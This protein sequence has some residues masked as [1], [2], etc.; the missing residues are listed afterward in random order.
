MATTAG[1][2]VWLF[3]VYP[4]AQQS[5][6]LGHDTALSWLLKALVTALGRARDLQLMPPSV[7]ATTAAAFDEL[8]PTAEQSVLDGHDRPLRSTSP[9]G[10]ARD[11]QALPPVVVETTVAPLEVDPTAKQTFV[12]GHETP[13]RR[14]PRTL[15]GASDLHLAPPLIV[16]TMTPSSAAFCPTAQQSFVLGH[17]TAVS[18]L[19]EPGRASDVQVLPPSVVATTAAPFEVAPTAQQSFLVGHE[20]AVSPL[21]NVLVMRL[22]RV[23]VVHVP[24][25][26]VVATTAAE[27]ERVRVPTAQQSSLFGHD[28]PSRST[29]PLGRSSDVQVP[30]PSVVAAT[31]AL[32]RPYPTAQQSA[33]VGQDTLCT[34]RRNGGYA[35]CRLHEPANCG[36]V[37]AARAADELTTDTSTRTATHRTEAPV[38]MTIRVDD[39][40]NRGVPGPKA[41]FLTVR[42]PGPPERACH[43]RAVVIDC[44]PT[45][46]GK[47]AHLLAKKPGAGQRIDDG[48]AATAWGIAG[49]GSSS[50]SS[51]TLAPSDAPGY[52]DCTVSQRAG[53]AARPRR[54]Q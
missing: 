42:S 39:A 29:I 41:P 15:A 31:A 54:Q 18:P 6:V 46:E 3:E 50:P 53:N 19:V 26:S 2:E 45:V 20:T 10:R 23:S 22:G 24:P 25:P 8:K 47:L 51:R 1:T 44:A 40:G 16:A 36:P 37:P 4:T 35:F 33:V 17:E 14:A 34:W 52:I 5:R 11:F 27:F 7:V 9:L 28:R 12:L 38:E 43:P 48:T 21:L 30:P 32:S 13:S 49:D